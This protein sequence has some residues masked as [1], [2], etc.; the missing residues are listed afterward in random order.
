M[1]KKIRLI[2]PL[3]GMLTL[4]V[5]ANADGQE[6]YMK[7]CKKC[8]GETGAG[9]TPMGKKFAVADYSK[10]EV[11]SAITDE[12]VA[13]AIKDGVVNDQG[14]KVMMAFGKKLSDEEVG[15]IVIEPTNSL[16][17]V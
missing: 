8:H 5:L 10:A 14:K 11:Q 7:Y 16:R 15:Q 1:L 12:A 2:L 4:P 9:D 17:L 6:L 3:L 13:K